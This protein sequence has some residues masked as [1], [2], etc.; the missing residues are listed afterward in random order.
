M[1]ITLWEEHTSAQPPWQT[2]ES[3]QI[4]RVLPV[5]KRMKINMC[6]TCFFQWCEWLIT[7]RK[8]PRSFFHLPQSIPCQTQKKSIL[9]PSACA[10]HELHRKILAQGCLHNDQCCFFFSMKA[11]GCDW[12]CEAASVR[13]LPA[14]RA[15]SKH[16]LLR[17]GGYKSSHL[18]LEVNITLC[19]WTQDG[20]QSAQSIVT[21]MSIIRI[22]RREIL[23]NVENKS[24][25]IRRVCRQKPRRLWGFLAG[26]LTASTWSLK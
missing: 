13:L 19:T 12:C 24:P 26:E 8:H 11:G 9:L 22:I 21:I 18:W 20:H 10:C 23:R 1:F 7:T 25:L 3:F 17:E 15:K 2:S 16:R 14:G 4:Y 6:F 5:W